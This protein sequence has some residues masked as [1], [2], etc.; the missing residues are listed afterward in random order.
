M[1]DFFFMF[2]YWDVCVHY[3]QVSTQECIGS[4]GAQV[5]GGCDLPN[6]DA[7]N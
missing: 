1:K 4:P 2:V 6:M 5:T 7:G 3:V